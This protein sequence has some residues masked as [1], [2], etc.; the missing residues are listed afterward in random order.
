MKDI[1]TSIIIPSYNG[2]ELL[3]ECIEAIRKYTPEKYEIIVV[4][5]GSEDRTTKYCLREKNPV[6]IPSEEQRISSSM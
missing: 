5:N 4:D 2:L 3:K 1:K 6:D